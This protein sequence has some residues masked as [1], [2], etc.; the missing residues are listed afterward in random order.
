MW[1]DQQRCIEDMH[2]LRQAIGEDQKGSVRG[3]VR[4][5][6]P[7]AFTRVVGNLPHVVEY[8]VH[9]T[10]LVGSGGIVIPSPS[11]NPQ[12]YVRGTAGPM[13][14]ITLAPLAG[15]DRIDGPANAI[16]T[17]MHASYQ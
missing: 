9:V 17:D 8:F 4:R 11:F 16:R 10:S 14:L 5:Q 12:G 3:Y 13:A 1:G 15:H 2:D 6:E 7:M